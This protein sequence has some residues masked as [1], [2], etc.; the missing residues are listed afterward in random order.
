MSV[1]AADQYANLT[2]KQVFEINNVSLHE[3]NLNC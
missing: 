1:R 3:T 2:N